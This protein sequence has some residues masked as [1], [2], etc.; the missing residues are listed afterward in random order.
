MGPIPSSVPYVL[1]ESGDIL[2][3]LKP[4][5]YL[6]HPVGDHTAPDLM[7]WLAASDYPHAQPVHRLD[8]GVSGVLLCA[9]TK[10]SRTQLGK[11]L[12]AQGVGKVYW[13]LVRGVTRAKGI[14]RRPLKDARR[15]KS[16]SATTRYARLESFSP[17]Y[18]LLSV[19]LE[20]G[21]KHQIRRHLEGINHPI[22][23]DRRY[24][25]RRKAKPGESTHRIWL[26]AGTLSLP[27]GTVFEAPLPRDLEDDLASLRSRYPD[28]SAETR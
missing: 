25:G 18:S 17:D 7:A 24:R 27:D 20:T 13:A 23:G 15:K 5:H 8:L 1:R 11:Q 12:E 21:R 14:I 16:I 10:E 26:H 4:S 6:V 9:L 19:T 28:P 22:V 3:V 2:A